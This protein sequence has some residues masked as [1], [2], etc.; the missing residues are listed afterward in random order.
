LQ[1]TDAESLREALFNAAR[2]HPERLVQTKTDQHGQ[3]FVLAFEMS[4]AVGTGIV[5]SIWIVPAG[6]E[7]VLRFI[8]CYIQ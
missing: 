2:N 7:D 4:T 8:S 1:P 6:E 3:H 5:R